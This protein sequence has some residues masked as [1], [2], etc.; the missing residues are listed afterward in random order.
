MKETELKPCPFCEGKD[1][2]LKDYTDRKYG[3]DGYEIKCKCGCRM[4]SGSVHEHY[5]E[6]KRYCTP[7]TEKSKNNAL[8]DL[9]ERWNRRADNEQREAD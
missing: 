5:W 4:A 6:G 3:F 1:L 8:K 2:E 7:I 9:Y